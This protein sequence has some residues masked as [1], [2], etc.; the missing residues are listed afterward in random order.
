V[1]ALFSKVDVAAFV[2]AQEIGDCVARTDLREMSAV[3]RTE[4]V[5]VDVRHEERARS[6]HGFET[7]RDVAVDGS[8]ERVPPADLAVDGADPEHF[9]G[10]RVADEEIVDGEP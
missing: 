3:A 7:A 5:H 1:A 10:R 6:Q 8:S 2:D 4:D 9:A